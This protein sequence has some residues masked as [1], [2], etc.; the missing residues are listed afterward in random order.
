MRDGQGHLDNHES[1]RGR[2]VIASDGGATQ[3]ALKL[4]TKRWQWLLVSALGLLMATLWTLPRGFQGSLRILG[5]PS[6]DLTKH[7]WNLWWFREEVLQGQLPFHTTY[8]NF[9][10]GLDL[11]PIEPLNMLAALIL[12]GPL[13]LPLAT[14]LIALLNLTLACL[15]M[16]ALVRYLSGAFWSALCAGLLYA[17]SSYALWTVY[18]GVGELSNLGWLPLALLFFLRFAREGGLRNGLLAT[19]LFFITAF[20]CWYYALFLY[21]VAG[22]L[23]LLEPWRGRQTP[24]L[25]LRYLLVAGLSLACLYPIVS[26]FNR[27]YRTE[28]RVM[29]PLGTF[30]ARRIQAQP[31]DPPQTR[32]D[33]R[34]LWIGGA[35]VRAAATQNPYLGGRYLGITIAVL[36]LAGLLLRPKHTWRWL[37]VFGVTLLLA[38]GSRLVWAG[39]ETG[40]LLPFAWFNLTLQRYAQGMNFPARF[41][42]P[43]TLCITVMAGLGL[44]GLEVRLR[45]LLAHPRRRRRGLG[46]ALFLLIGLSPL[47]EARLRG[48]VPTP[49]PSL[50]VRAMPAAYSLANLGLEPGAVLEIPQAFQAQSRRESDELLLMQIIHER[51]SPGLPLDRISGFVGSARAE[52][53]ALPLVAAMLALTGRP[54]LA[55]PACCESSPS[56]SPE[57]A[58]SLTALNAR[59]IRY[60]IVTYKGLQPAQ[61]ARLERL[62]QR[63]FG[64]PLFQSQQQSLHRIPEAG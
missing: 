19:G 1:S 44:S 6:S 36:A 43:V 23:A 42:M 37:L 5:H 34:Q 47:L 59:G 7:Y 24:T 17:L 33:L 54:A 40:A 20:S 50:P 61:R 55:G 13:G 22:L 39:T 15:G 31:R 28:V 60:L 11:Y 32:V 16:F 18:V 57:V 45:P 35:Q 29:E 58:S 21:L 49:L 27:S 25:W 2:A 14:N 12:G 62:V 48:D 41:M 8:L 64:P 38:L 10:Q 53:R 52:L 56:D 9:P 26:T 30:I 46:L 51:P 4:K 3:Q 63:H